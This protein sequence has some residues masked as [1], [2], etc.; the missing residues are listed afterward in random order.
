M[1]FG[2]KVGS[3]VKTTKS[4]KVSSAA[5]KRTTVTTNTIGTNAIVQLRID[6]RERKSLTEQNYFYD[7]LVKELL[8]VAPGSGTDVGGAVGNGVLSI[9]QGNLD[10]GDFQIIA[11]NKPYKRGATKNGVTTAAATTDLTEDL[12]EDA[13]GTVVAEGCDIVLIERK[14]VADYEASVKSKHI[15]EQYYRMKATPYRFKV[16]IVEG[17]G[18]IDHKDAVFISNGYRHGITTVFTR[19]AADTVRTV[20]L[21]VKKIARDAEARKITVDE[22]L[23]FTMIQAADYALNTKKCLNVS[24]STIL[25]SALRPIAGLGAQKLSL[26]MAEFGTLGELITGLRAG[27]TDPAVAAKYRAAWGRKDVG[28]KTETT[29]YDMICSKV[30]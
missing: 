15:H 4:T 5:V 3:K 1:K 12:S 6:N 28:R 9:S 26:V 29:Y 25:A 17:P 23:D 16:L 21:W 30:L 20:A 7:E 8:G 14:T 10:I 2:K 27:Q 11:K 24:K 19:N 18:S 22:E 13:S